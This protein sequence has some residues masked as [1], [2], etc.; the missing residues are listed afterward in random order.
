METSKK[1]AISFT[2]TEMTS[3][4]RKMQIKLTDRKEHNMA[5]STYGS[6]R[7]DVDAYLGTYAGD[8][9]VEGVYRELRDMGADEFVD[10]L[11]RHQR[12]E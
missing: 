6:L 12:E 11:V 9:D 5:R 7:E 3:F 8:Y 2:S 1:F 4:C 10:V